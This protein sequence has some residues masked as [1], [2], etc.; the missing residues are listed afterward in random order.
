MSKRAVASAK[1]DTMYRRSSSQTGVGRADGRGRAYIP[2]VKILLGVVAMLAA[3]TT[4]PVTGRKQLN[5]VGDPAKRQAMGRAGRAVLHANRG[6]LRRLIG[7]IE[8]S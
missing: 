4:A 6:A 8:N 7:L 3:C 5:L 1:E 2:G